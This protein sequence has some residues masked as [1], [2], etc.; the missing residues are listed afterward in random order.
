[1]QNGHVVNGSLAYDLD[2]DVANDTPIDADTATAVMTAGRNIY[3][4]HAY[5]PYSQYH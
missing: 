2:W 5:F 4:A 3:A 1:M